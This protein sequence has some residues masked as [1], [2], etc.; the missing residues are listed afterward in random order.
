MYFVHAVLIL[1]LTV[2]A[3]AQS[4]R[5]AT[6]SKCTSTATGDI[7]FETSKA[8]FSIIRVNSGSCYP[9]A[10]GMRRTCKRGTPF[11]T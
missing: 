5:S 1:N 11:F 3:S 7:E 9:G 8:R 4:E 10:T 2:C 6:T